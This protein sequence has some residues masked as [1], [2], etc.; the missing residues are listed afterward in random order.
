MD[1]TEC[2][3]FICEFMGYQYFKEFLIHP[4]SEKPSEMLKPD[5]LK[6]HC[7]WD[8]IMP[9]IERIESISTPTIEKIWVSISGKS[10]AMWNYFSPMEVLRKNDV[11]NIYRIKINSESKLK[12]TWLACIDYIKWY[13]E[14]NKK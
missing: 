1:I 6:Y 10:C 7:S 3:I 13:N 4:G 5:E 2:N 8:W 12:A 11:P 14:H 9:V